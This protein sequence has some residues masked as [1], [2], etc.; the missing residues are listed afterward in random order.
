MEVTNFNSLAVED[1][2]TLLAGCLGLR[3]WVDELVAGR[4]YDSADLYKASSSP[5]AR[6]ASALL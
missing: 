6:S 2:T 3:R 1:A 4:P 5:H